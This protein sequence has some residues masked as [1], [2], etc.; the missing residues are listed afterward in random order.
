[1]GRFEAV[2]ILPFLVLCLVCVSGADPTP[3]FEKKRKPGPSDWLA[4]FK[5][6]HRTFKDYRASRPVRAH[7]GDVLRF[8]PTGEFDEKGQ[9]LL[10]QTIAFSSIWFDLPVDVTKAQSLP[11]KGWQRLNGGQRQVRTPWFLQHLLPPFRKDDAVCVSAITMA[12]LYPDEKW[13]FVFGEAS[14]RGRVGVWSFARLSHGTPEVALR[15]CCKLV[16]HEIGHMFGLH[17]CV[18]YECDMNG[19]NHLPEL[20]S[21]P[22]HLCPRCLR[23]LVWNRGWKRAA[24]MERYRKLCAFYEKYG[25]APEAK[26]I[27]RRL[28]SLSAANPP[29]KTSRPG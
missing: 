23:K 21:Q 3:L 27:K 6:P 8:V 9:A 28:A 1:M 13:N 16:V 12:D 5:E 24:V 4:R 11:K 2:R 15:R 18:V 25:L 29:S 26:W 17:H 7:K 10:E 19:S 20:D 14:L 22:L